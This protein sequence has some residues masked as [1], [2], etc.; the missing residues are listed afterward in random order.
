MTLLK[1]LSGFLRIEHT[2][3]SLP[4]IFA[5][6]FLAAGGIFSAQIFV[7]IVLAGTGA[8]TV[9]LALNRIF[10]RKIDRENPRT[11]ERE[12][13]SGKMSMSE[14]VAVAAG[15]A[16]LYFVSAYLICPLVFI[17]SPLPLVAFTVYPLMKRFTSLC[18]F[19]VGISLALGPLGGWL[20]VRCS[21]E[22][23]DPAVVLSVFTFLWISGFDIIYATA[24]EEFDRRRG[25]YSLV[26]R[27]GRR[28]ALLVSR[29]SHLLSFGCLVF[30]YILSF[31]T[32]FALLPLALCGYLLYLEHR[33]FGRVDSVFFRTNIL[34]GFAVLFF[35]LAGIY[36]P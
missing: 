7:L 23:M 21:F 8:R 33:S 16:L 3:F 5:G 14:A 2:F 11:S 29:I 1:N 19:G 22:Q 26:A 9:A 20:A 27:F 6:A 32:L 34:I 18:H 15:G 10:D 25:I 28:R 35:T 30:L 4:V 13:P 17:L 12:L 36:L 31:R 24:D